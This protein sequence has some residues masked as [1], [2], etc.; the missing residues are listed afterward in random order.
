MLGLYILL[1]FIDLIIAK[2]SL[3]RQPYVPASNPLLYNTYIV[4]WDE[5]AKAHV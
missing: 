4:K 1:M 5:I 2:V 3:Y